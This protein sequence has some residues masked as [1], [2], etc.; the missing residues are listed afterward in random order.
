MRLLLVED[1]K[2]LSELVSRGL[3][4]AG[5][6]VDAVGTVEDAS[7]ALATSEYDALVLD[8]GLPDGDG[9]DVLRELRAGRDGTPV[10]VL[11]ARDGLD[12][13]VDGLN[14][15]ADDYL[16]KPFAM[17]ELVARL[18]ALLRRPSGALGTFLDVGNI[19]FDT[20][21]REVG[22]AGKPVSLSRRELALLENLMRRAGHVVAKDY[23]EDRIYGFEDEVSSNSLEVL[24]HRLRKKLTEQDSSAG[25]HTIRGIGYLL[26]ESTG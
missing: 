19:S 25:I 9:M 10:L 26:S 12:D 11:T 21:H 8:L 14:S 17:P 7:A 22:I 18:K 2:R 6:T 4:R 24:I 15:G 13:R 1:E 3:G 23:L 5:F 16:L 20:V